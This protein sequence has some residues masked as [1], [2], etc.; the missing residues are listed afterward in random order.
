MT[1]DLKNPHYL[2]SCLNDLVSISALS[3]VWDGREPMR[4]ADSLARV[5]LRVLDVD[6]VYLRF[7]SQE[8]LRDEEI[9]V[10]GRQTGETFDAA[11]FGRRLRRLIGRETNGQIAN[12]PDPGGSGRVSIVFTG[13]GTD[14]GRG[15]IAVAS[16][17]AGFPSEVDR[18]LIRTAV[19]QATIALQRA[20]DQRSRKGGT[21][22]G[23]TRTSTRPDR[24]AGSGGNASDP[25]GRVIVGN[26]KAIRYVLHLVD[27]VAKTPATV[28]IQG[29]TGTGKELVARAIHESSDRNSEAFVRINCAAI[30]GGLLEAE[31]FG[32]EKGAFTGATRRRSGRFEQADRGT[33][34][35]D[36]ISEIP[37]EL[38]AKLLRVLQEQEFERLGSGHTLR[39]DVR[40]IA[41]SNRNLPA[42]VAEGRFRSDLYYRLNV[43]P[44]TLPPLRERAEDIPELV[45][46]FVR[47]QAVRYCKPVP[48]ISVA[49]LQTLC[50]HAWPGNV[51]ELANLVE[52]SVILSSGPVLELPPL[53][54]MPPAPAV[55]PSPTLA[56][57]EREHIL[58]VLDASRWVVGGPSG[59]AA[60]LGMKRTS[61][62]YR[63]Q[64]LGIS[65]SG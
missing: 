58:R 11:E 9:C 3:A 31:L 49:A 43:F 41:A 50:R 65:R 63:M 46:H 35:L 37:L 61:L 12:V 24:P 44:V 52:R 25:A 55:S 39:V 47:Q 53:E 16:G 13:L 4:I 2:Q 1:G 18:L 64:K 15:M 14:R 23:S 38:Q 33:I 5:M 32:H 27:Q 19:N 10:H 36:E 26:G 29:E 6:F 8:H 59:A 28:L 45:R 30:P 40:L 34:F 62:Q 22:S 7:C 51:R 57:F 60:R 17:K 42:M 56:D 20:D 21:G 48:E 54:S